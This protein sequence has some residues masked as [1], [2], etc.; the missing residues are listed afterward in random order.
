MFSPHKKPF[1]CVE[2]FETFWDFF[3]LFVN[4]LILHVTHEICPDLYILKHGLFQYLFQNLV[5]RQELLLV[6]TKWSDMGNK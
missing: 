2:Q 4:K 6:Q 3:W 5:L 1:A